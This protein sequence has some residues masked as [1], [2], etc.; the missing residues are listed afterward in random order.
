MKW[1]EHYYN[2]CIS[3]KQCFTKILRDFIVCEVGSSIS[4]ERVQC[5][6]INMQVVENRSLQ[7]LICALTYCRSAHFYAH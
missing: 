7:D 2:A 3:R 4:V 6:R 1:G 5:P